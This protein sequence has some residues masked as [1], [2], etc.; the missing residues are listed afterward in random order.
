MPRK[1]EVLPESISQ[2]IAAGEVIERPASVVKELMENAID[3]GSSEIT[4]ELNAG[5]LQLIRVVDNGEGMDQE[6]VPVAFRRYAT[7]KIKKAEDLYAIHTLG[8]RGEA[9]PSISQIS[10]VTLRTRTSHSLSGT[11]LICEGG[12]IKS[13][14]EIGC[15]LGTE[16]EVRNLFYNIPVKRKFLKSIRSELR[17]VLNHFLRLSLSHPM[18]SFKFIHDGRTLHEH[19]KT[20]SPLVRIEVIFGKEICRHLRP[21][22]FEDGKISL[23]GF[24]S[25]PSFSKRNG[26]GVYFYVNQR[27]IKDRM[28]YKAILDAYRH[29]L[30]SHQFPVVIL[31]ISL[32]PSAVDVNV[33]PTKTEVKFM[34]PERIYQ[35]VFAAIRM[36]LEEGSSR[37]E[38]MGPVGGRGEWVFQKGGRPSFW[39]HETLSAPS[40]LTGGKEEGILTVQDGAGF[41]WEAEK[42]WPYTILGQIRGT[43]ILCEGEENL[44]FIDQHAA[45]ERILFEKFK[46]EFENRS[47]ISEK[48]LL[49]ILIDLSVEESYILESA[50]EALKAIG[51]E[52]ESIGEKLFAIRSIPSFINQK[53]PK[54]MV[55]G[56]LDELS[57]LEKQGKG[58]ETIHTI[59]VTLACHS[60]IR[61]NFILNK[62]EMDKLAQHLIPFPP[63]TTCPHGRPIFFIFP[64]DELKKQFKRK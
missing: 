38:D 59:L 19:L 21:I 18:I 28:I 6:D 42:K 47:M 58:E 37:G 36:V 27:F 35:V 30:P 22:E 43:Y 63:S 46:K 49:P 41:Q 61:G 12:R 45:H 34:D 26:E 20:E 56:I 40:S 55:R 24:A 10:K 52:I 5:G 29:I 3:A 54:E 51:F 62:E 11:K 9:L 7:S 60:A 57:F 32:P 17:Y 23:L 4:L 1:I 2:I 50:E 14:S 53:E 64:L 8:F 39:G 13:I 16:V 15:P 33:H 31:F 48:L 44:I 25:L